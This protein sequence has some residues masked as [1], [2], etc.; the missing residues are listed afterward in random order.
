LQIA[1]TPRPAAARAPL[2]EAVQQYEKELILDALKAARGNRLQA[3]RL[4]ETTERII[5]YKIRKY[6][7]DTQRFRDGG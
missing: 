4:L 7:I 3:A 1:A 5:G 2:G 6:G